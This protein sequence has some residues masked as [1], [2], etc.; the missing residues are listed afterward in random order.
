MI[1]YLLMAFFQAAEP[2][3][4]LHGENGNYFYKVNF[5]C[6]SSLEGSYVK[7]ENNLK[8]PSLILNK[9]LKS[10][11][12]N[13]SLQVQFEDYIAECLARTEVLL[14]IGGYTILADDFISKKHVFKSE[15]EQTFNNFTQHS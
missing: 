14:R 11:P 3:A 1:N 7:Y 10:L 6:V 4:N 9:F 8:T 13:D 2:G 5:N 12:I 15:I